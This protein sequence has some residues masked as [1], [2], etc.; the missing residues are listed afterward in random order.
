MQTIEQTEPLRQ[1]ISDW[2]RRGELIAFVPT[3]GNLHAGH[4]SLVEEARRRARRVVVSIFVNPM[5]F[6][7]G[8]D[9]E[10]YPRTLAEDSRMLKEAGVDLLFAPTVAE[11]YPR[12]HG[13]ATRIEVPEV[14]EG[15]CGEFRPGHFVGVATVVAKLFNLVQPDIAVFGQKDYQQLA[16]IRRMV[17]DLCF[18]I[19]IIGAPTV[20]E[21]DGLAL[22]SRNGY[23]SAS[24][25]ARAPLIYQLLGRIARAIGQGARD[26]RR[27]EAEAEA[28]LKAAGFEP[29]YISVR[30][31]ET[32]KVAEAGD[33][34]LVV[35]AAARLGTTRLIDNLE[36]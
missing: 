23:L 25:R 14:S 5:Q 31:R 33:R 17:T 28:E 32:L 20:R 34:A 12:G 10:R 1:K 36:I 22:S 3:M 6:G 24:E 21:A 2:R 26:F 8:E 7:P 13:A 4:M 30:Q 11:I 27:L 16:V 35:L 9:F 18:P 29:E 15:L 19:E